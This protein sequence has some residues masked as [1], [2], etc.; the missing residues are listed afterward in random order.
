MYV[1]SDY[2][3]NQCPKFYL[4][5][6][7]VSHLQIFSPQS[8]ISQQY[9]IMTYC[10][11]TILQI[12]VIVSYKINYNRWIKWAAASNSIENIVCW[13]WFCTIYIYLRHLLHWML[14]PRFS[15]TSNQIDYKLLNWQRI[16]CFYRCNMQKNQLRGALDFPDNARWK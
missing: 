4:I 2:N 12:H 8:R 15:F 13:W 3:P 16:Q 5:D 9:W 7:P 14:L 6:T 11:F 1:H 10:M